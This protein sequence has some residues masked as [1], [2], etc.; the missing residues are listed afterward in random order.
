MHR[1]DATATDPLNALSHLIV[2]VTGLE[3]G[4][5]LVFP[6]LGRQSLFDSLLA[7]AEDLGIL[8]F[9]SKSPFV[10][11]AASSSNGNSPTMTAVSSFWF[12]LNQEIALEKGLALSRPL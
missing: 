1:S 11:A 6:I 3:H 2:N 4:P 12:Q 5:W 7:V 10:V 9:H 8:S